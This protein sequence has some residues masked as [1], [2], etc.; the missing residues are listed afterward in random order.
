[1]E[2]AAGP[3]KLGPKY[4]TTWVERIHHSTSRRAE[5]RR[6]PPYMRQLVGRE[7]RACVHTASAATVRTVQESRR[8]PNSWRFCA[9]DNP[10]D[11]DVNQ[12]D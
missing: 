6:K 9:K 11:T 4:G 1:M 10:P 2:N 7:C 12:N 5:G 8:Q 3:A